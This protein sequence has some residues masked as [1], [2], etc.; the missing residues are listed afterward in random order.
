VKRL[1]AVCVVLLATLVVGVPLWLVVATSGKSQGQ[2]L[3][4]NLSPPVQWHLAENY[5]RAFDQGEVLSGLV[6]S[7]TIVLPTLVLVILFGA[8]A[9]W[10]LAR[11]ASRLSSMV[12]AVAISGILIP[13]G[14]VTVVLELRHLGLAGSSFGL[15]GVYTGM[16]LATVI[17]FIT[18]FVRTLPIELEE[19]ATVDGAGPVRTF[20][21]VV[22]PLLR[23]VIATATILVS[24]YAWNDVFYAFFVLGGGSTSTLPLNL[25][26]VANAGLYLNNWHL[27]FAYVVL[28]SGPMVAAFVV[29]QRKVISGITSGAVK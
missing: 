16:Y 24:L 10:I 20:F 29:A 7:L 18:G 21:T 15:I 1:R 12:Y 28:V 11:R 5:R 2:A 27:I 17:F 13:P 6:G 3:A 25:F 19:A 26:E 22:L 23:P 9:S 4:P 8:M 14:I